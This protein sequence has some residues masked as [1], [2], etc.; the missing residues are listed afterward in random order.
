[1]PQFYNPPSSL[2]DISIYT[3]IRAAVAANTATSGCTGNDRPQ[4]YPSNR[5]TCKADI[6]YNRTDE[7]LQKELEAE[8]CLFGNSCG[9]N[10]RAV[11][12]KF[13]GIGGTKHFLTLDK[14][15]CFM[16]ESFCTPE[17]VSRY[18]PIKK[19]MRSNA[20]RTGLSL[21]DPAYDPDEDCCGWCTLE[22]GKV[23][24]FYWPDPEADT[25]CLSIIGD[26]LPI[27]YGATT[28]KSGAVYWGCT[29]LIN[30]DPWSERNGQ[31][32]TATTARLWSTD[33]LLGVG[34]STKKYELDP[35]ADSKSFSLWCGDDTR[36]P[37]YNPVTSKKQRWIPSP[38]D[39][40]RPLIGL[41]KHL[42]GLNDWFAGCDK[43]LFQAFDPPRSLEPAPT[44]AAN[45]PGQNDKAPAP[46]KMVAPDLPEQTK[47]KEQAQVMVPESVNIAK[48][49]PT[50]AA[51]DT[52]KKAENP[53]ATQQP[54]LE[55]KT[56]DDPKAGGQ[57]PN[58]KDGSAKSNGA[59]NAKAPSDAP[60]KQ[61]GGTPSK[62]SGGGDQDPSALANDPLDPA[63]QNKPKDAGPE[64]KGANT[65]SSEHPQQYSSAGSQTGNDVKNDIL[66]DPAPSSSG[67]T[68]DSNKQSP[69]ISPNSDKPAGDGVSS[70]PADVAGQG[71]SYYG[72]QEPNA[73]EKD[74]QSQKHGG[75]NQEP[76][77]ASGSA[78]Q[79][80]P[81][82]DP[83]NASSEQMAQIHDA[84]AASS[85][86]PPTSPPKKAT[87][88]QTD[89]SEQQH[90]NIQA[91]SNGPVGLG[92]NSKVQ[93]DNP[94]N[95]QQSVPGLDAPTTDNEPTTN[96][97]QN[98]RP[99]QIGQQGDNKDSS[100]AGSGGSV[101][102]AN[103]ISQD[104]QQAKDDSQSSMEP[105]EPQ[106]G[107]NQPAKPTQKDQTMQDNNFHGEDTHSPPVGLGDPVNP[108]D[109]TNKNQ[110]SPQG[111]KQSSSDFQEP[112]A[113]SNSPNDVSQND[114]NSQ[115]KSPAG[116][117]QPQSSTAKGQQSDP[118][119][120]G[121]PDEGT[122]GSNTGPSEDDPSQL[123]YP[124]QP[125][126]T[127]ATASQAFAF[128]PFGATTTIA[129]HPMIPL[130]NRQGISIAGMTLSPQ[131]PVITISGTEISVGRSAIVIGGSSVQYAAA[132]DRVAKTTETTGA[133]ASAGAGESAE[134]MSDAGLIVGTSQFVGG[135][136]MGGLQG[137]TPTASTRWSK[138]ANHSSSA[139]SSAGLPITS[140]NA[141]IT[142]TDTGTTSTVENKPSVFTTAPFKSAGCSREVMECSLRKLRLV[143]GTLAL[144]FVIL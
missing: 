19:W 29:S 115:H 66:P 61:N 137:P 57:D 117:G 78:A 138:F 30:D 11:Q 118:L 99:F 128:I 23:D 37:A 3:P 125:H 136:V 45:D 43:G 131:A 81:A 25:S 2:V 40:Y 50:P 28:G 126:N 119:L 46:A 32:E 53:P 18:N 12:D 34:F 26:N 109:Q 24:V 89:G 77:K 38:G 129:S 47:A 65:A 112:Q 31:Y 70:N 20:C 92:P 108:N 35:Y 94:Q 6:V 13:F 51:V 96:S 15:G 1:M 106:S 144:S 33:S 55:Q 16:N 8:S 17:L 105:Q 97:A 132:P 133:S 101:S 4:R 58:G 95:S 85:S 44:M 80:S 98:A 143:I 71:S 90:Q 62:P 59:N 48:H 14:T 102:S 87:Q 139:L 93:Q 100:P 22:G 42:A 67:Y 107:S 116:D 103:Q 73:Q 135:L 7:A 41:P 64:S 10:E 140:S 9:A 82:I 54:S 121:E 27:D 68:Q 21:Y 36:M 141:S 63:E 49:T 76:Q 113:G 130:P 114:V 91:E 111:N 83:D 88:E 104:Q 79:D 134:P 56:G 5:T 39:P 84:L 75:D 69:P 120:N 124:K 52:Q 74:P 127:P 122:S 86:S 72:N 123:N 142:M 60:N 110:Q